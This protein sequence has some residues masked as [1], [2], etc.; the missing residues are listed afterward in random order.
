MSL[1]KSLQINWLSPEKIKKLSFGKVINHKTINP[2]TL[3][4]ELGG[5]FDP[6]IFGPSL[7]YEC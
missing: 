1:I 7:N 3:K 6:V 5:I 4:P 2:R